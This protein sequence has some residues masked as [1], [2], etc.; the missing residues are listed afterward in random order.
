MKK[1]LLSFLMLLFILSA[2]SQSNIRIHSVT[3]NLGY[4]SSWAVDGP[5]K[6]IELA[7][8]WQKNL[9]ILEFS[10]DGHMVF[11]VWNTEFNVLYG[12]NFQVAKWF[13][14]EPNAGIG[15]FTK[16]EK[17]DHSLVEDQAVVGFPVKL[18]F[19][20]HADRRIDLGL[21]PIANFNSM[22]TNYGGALVL[23]YRFHNN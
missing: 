12:R 7:A 23:R 16:R 17:Q 6:G 3:V 10:H 11:P 9:F 15:I 20:Y 5:V 1:L 14:I 13:S 22:N 2:N 18:K 21:A 19:I 4:K 8:D